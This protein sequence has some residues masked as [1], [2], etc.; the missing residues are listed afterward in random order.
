[1]ALQEL[2]RW[3]HFGEGL[4]RVSIKKAASMKITVFRGTKEIG[5]SCIEVATASTRIVLDIGMPLVD[6][7]REPFDSWT[8]RG[9]SVPQLLAEGILPG[10]PGLFNEGN[11]PD[12][13]L[14]SHAHRDHVG[15]LDYS[16]PEIPVYASKGTS[17]M[18]MAASIFS[19]GSGI[20]RDRH[21]EI[22]A[23]Q[24]LVIGDMRI[25]PYAVD[26]SAFDSLAFLVEADGKKLLYSGD[27]RM[28]GRK[29]WMGEKLVEEV[30]RLKID[31]LLMEGTHFGGDRERGITEIELEDRFVEIVKDAP[32]LVLAAFS[33]MDVDRLVSFYKAARR[34]DRIFVADAYAAFILYLVASQAKIPR[35]VEEAGIRVYFNRA[36]EQKG[37]AFIREKFQDNQITLEEIQKE[38]KKHLMVFRPSMVDLDF[39]GQLPGNSRCV[40]SY[41]KGYL[42]KPD[43][44]KLQE[45]LTQV[46][47]DFVPAHTSG[48]IFIADII[49]FVNAIKPKMVGPIHTFE[50][51]MFHK[52]FQNVCELRDGVSVEVE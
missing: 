51:Q 42:K 29:S 40:Y 27:L 30:S 16:R 8:L 25:T 50:P 49:Q 2:L 32:G 14:L 13:I 44:I 20:P 52:H 22:K 35:P 15:F 38:P 37:L 11:P 21:V 36:F 10:V 9:K 7:A 12:G 47:G 5:G 43:W 48:H 34:A 45:Q 19:K 23:G 33:P 6:A 18:M 39:Q 28:H 4:A 24:E 31:M 26:H 41:W 1:M 17:K 3:L 46:T